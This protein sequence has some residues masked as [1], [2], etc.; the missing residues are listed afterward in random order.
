[1]KSIPAEILIYMFCFLHQNDK[2][3]CMQVCHEWNS[4]IKSTVLFETLIVS[5]KEGLESLQTLLQH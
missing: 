2:L 1:M 4:V 5:F 3:Q